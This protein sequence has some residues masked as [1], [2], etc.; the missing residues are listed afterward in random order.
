M[1]I[2]TSL[3]PVRFQ[4]IS[5]VAKTAL[6]RLNSQPALGDALEG[7]QQP[8]TG[9]HSPIQVQPIVSGGQAQVIRPPL[10]GRYREKR[11]QDY[12]SVTSP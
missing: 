5:A 4:L 1:E 11:A 10:L 9:Q 6:A 3:G 8:F 7:Q 12:A 2:N